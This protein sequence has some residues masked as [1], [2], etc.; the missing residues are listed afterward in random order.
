MIRI[1][2]LGKKYFVRDTTTEEPIHE[3]TIINLRDLKI[4]FHHADSLPTAAEFDVFIR[5][6]RS[7]LEG[8]GLSATS[9]FWHCA[10]SPDYDLWDVIG[11]CADHKY[12]VAIVDVIH[13]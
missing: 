5:E 11:P 12:P 2:G 6:V 13:E 9:V 1:M 7:V 8:H 10:H 3:V 4:T